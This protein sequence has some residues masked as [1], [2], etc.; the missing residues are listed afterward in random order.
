VNG[1]KYDFDKYDKMPPAMK[2][3]FNKIAKQLKEEL[4]R[5]FSLS[6]YDQSNLTIPRMTAEQHIIKHL[7]ECSF[8]RTHLKTLA[9]IPQHM[10]EY[11]RTLNSKS[12][13]GDMLTCGEV[14]RY[15]D[16]RGRIRRGKVHHN[17]N[18]MWW[19]VRS[20]YEWDNIASF[21]ILEKVT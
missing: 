6:Y 12:G 2:K 21:D 20:K 16:W 17:I 9:A 13:V 3:A 18:N 19:V 10:T 5:K 1:G 7:N 8:D 4:V 15:R 11:D 14:R